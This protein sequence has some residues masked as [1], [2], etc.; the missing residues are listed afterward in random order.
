MDKS[1]TKELRHLLELEYDVE[2]LKMIDGY[3]DGSVSHL[4]LAARVGNTGMLLVTE[5]KKAC[6]KGSEMED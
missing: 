4:A 2:I 3:V 1:N 5:Y 6:L